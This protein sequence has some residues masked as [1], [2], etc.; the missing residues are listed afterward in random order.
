ML[1]R[2]AKEVKFDLHQPEKGKCKQFNKLQSRTKF[3]VK[4]YKQIQ[5]KRNT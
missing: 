1:V 4:K 3:K 2:V 5:T